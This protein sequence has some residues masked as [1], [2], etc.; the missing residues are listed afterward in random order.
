MKKLLKWIGILVFLLIVCTIGYSMG[1]GK[2][3]SPGTESLFP[4]ATP[5]PTLAPGETSVPLPTRTT[6][7]TKTAVPTKRPNLELLDTSTRSDTYMWYI[8]GRVRNNTDRKYGYVQIT[9][10]LYD[11]A[12]SQV[13]STMANVNNLEPGG[14]WAF[15]ALVLEQRAKRYKVSDLTGF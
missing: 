8:T 3:A 6:A 14:I 4:T 11:D 9:F 15:E 12:G 5:L 7:P 10:N 2:R 13:G 1:G